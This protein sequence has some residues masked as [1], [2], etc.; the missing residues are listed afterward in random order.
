[1]QKI[2]H[3]VLAMMTLSIALGV[4]A[5]GKSVYNSLGCSSCHGID[6]KPS[7]SAY[8]TLA[9]KDAVWL[10]NQ[11]KYFQFGVRKDPTMNAMVPIVAG[12]EQIIA[13]YLSKQ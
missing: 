9:G 6:G 1:M 10:V 2:L 8:P 5:S 4:Q 3:Y 11:L 12:Y 13:D 7:T